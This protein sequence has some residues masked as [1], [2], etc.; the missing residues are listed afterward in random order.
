MHCVDYVRSLAAFG[1]AA[2]RA[3]TL[4]GGHLIGLEAEP[5]LAG[6]DRKAWRGRRPHNT[7]A[8]GGGGDW[9]GCEAAL[10]APEGAGV[11]TGHL[12][13]TPR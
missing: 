12:H 2:R 13:I 6:E 11:T 4:A 8:P 3:L 10:S 5:R 9:R 1:V 7:G